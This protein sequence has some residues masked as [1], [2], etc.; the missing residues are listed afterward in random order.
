M[1]AAI[2]TL[3]ENK[4]TELN[5]NKHA[6]DHYNQYYGYLIAECEQEIY[7]LNIR[8]QL[9][10]A[11]E[12]EE[13][14]EG[15]NTRPLNAEAAAFVPLPVDE[16]DE[17]DEGWNRGLAARQQMVQQE[18]HEQ[19]VAEEYKEFQEPAHREGTKLKWISSTNP[20]TYRVAIVKK[21][22]ILEV[23]RVTDGA[24]HCHDT[25]LCQCRPCSEIRLS[26]RLGAPMPPWLSRVPL[27]KTFFATEADWRA[28][29]PGGG[30]RG[31]I[32][33]T[34]PAISA[35]TLKKLCCTP[36]KMMTDG[37]RLEELEE[38]FPGG[39]MVL[40]TSHGQLEIESMNSEETNQY[41]IFCK[42]TSEIRK[43]FS[44]LGTSPRSNGKPQLMVE[45]RGLYV[46]LSHLF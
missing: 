30:L 33:T 24:G 13:A 29:L 10:G 36:L 25:T 11:D 31:S 34:V 7:D 35:R 22:G 26:R 6:R 14:E 17:D 18:L 27:L 3:I 42:A 28:S 19:E 43:K 40:T 21:D 41:R 32:K 39:I 5:N 23:K 2:Q 15:W 9:E 20:E 37:G 44:E 16:D 12:R 8:F 38:R 46:D 1:S 4:E 45:W